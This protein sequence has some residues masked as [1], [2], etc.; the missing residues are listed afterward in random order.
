MQ[1]PPKAFTG[2]DSMVVEPAKVLLIK[3]LAD[4]LLIIESKPIESLSPGLKFL[5]FPGRKGSNPI[6]DSL[7]LFFG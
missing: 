6:F 4:I 7:V 3:E 2:F 5:E 1:W